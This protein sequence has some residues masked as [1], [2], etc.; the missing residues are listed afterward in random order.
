MF[1]SKKITK[2][3]VC[4]AATIV[5]L[6]LVI[7]FRFMICGFQKSTAQSDTMGTYSLLAAD[8]EGCLDFLNQF[9]IIVDNKPVEVSKVR[10]P[11]VF[12]EVY[13][14]YN[15][16]QKKQGLD[17]EDY[18]GKECE[19]RTYNV[20]D[21]GEDNVHANLLIYDGKVIGGDICST[22]LDGFMKT[23]DGQS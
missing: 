15:R 16:L 11:S 5:L 7:I 6:L 3:S 21:C 9:E 1:V 12:N 4:I 23:F 22:R 19:K 20:K 17:L 18:K 8:N 13:E 2:K 14:Q 10:I